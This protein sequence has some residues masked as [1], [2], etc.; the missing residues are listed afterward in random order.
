MARARNIAVLQQAGIPVRVHGRSPEEFYR[1]TAKVDNPLIRAI[2]NLSESWRRIRH[3][4]GFR[5]G[6]QCIASAIW[7]SLLEDV[8]LYAGAQVYT[9]VP[10]LLGSYLAVVLSPRIMPLYRAGRFFSFYWRTQLAVA[11][12]AIGLYGLFLASSGLLQDTLFPA[13]F[14][15]SHPVILVL[16]PGALA[17]MISFPLTLSFVMFLRP[18][19]LLWLDL[20]TLPLLVALYVYAIDGYGV[21]GAAWVTTG[22]R[23]A[24]TVIVQIVAWRWAR[25][26]G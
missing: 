18:R 13:S 6:R 8:G 3:G 7:R 25:G 1:S 4:I 22:M 26:S 11:G 23:L 17:G 15:A 9:M 2:R 16:M 5:A 19:F 12:V 10:D 14:D 21:V 24:K 20:A